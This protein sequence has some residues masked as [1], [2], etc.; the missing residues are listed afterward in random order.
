MI[1]YILMVTGQKVEMTQ[2]TRDRES[3]IDN[4]RLD[5]TDVVLDKCPTV[6]ER[7]QRPRDDGIVDVSRIIWELL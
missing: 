3:K 1:R 6:V 4:L 7:T 2:L 5:T